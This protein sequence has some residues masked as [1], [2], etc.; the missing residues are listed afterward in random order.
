MHHTEE[1]GEKHMLQEYILSV[2]D[3]SEIGCKRLRWMLQRYIECCNGYT[4][5]L[6]RPVPYIS[7]VFF[8]RML[9]MC[10]SGCCICFTR[11]LRVFFYLDIAYVCNVFRCF[12]KYFRSMFQVFHL[13]SFVFFQALASGCLKVDR[14]CATNLHLVSV[15]QIFRW[16]FSPPWQE[17]HALQQWSMAA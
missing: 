15:D 6:H 8:G 3:V 11:M 12:D 9:Q 2:L 16:C 10:L 4:H 13:S 1:E 17:D 7:P 14:A 5:I